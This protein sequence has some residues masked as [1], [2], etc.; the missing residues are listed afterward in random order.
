MHLHL[1]KNVYKLV[2]QTK[3]NVH[4]A[5][6]KW[7]AD[8]YLWKH[9]HIFIKIQFLYLQKYTGTP[10]LETFSPSRT[11][12]LRVT[13]AARLPPVGVMAGRWAL[14]RAGKAQLFLM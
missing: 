6:E 3:L 7:K 13:H 9:F 4:E 5:K 14:A 11:L 12:S 1:G 2:I 8:F 10:L